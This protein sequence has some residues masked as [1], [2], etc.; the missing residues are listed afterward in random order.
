M[1]PEDVIAD[2]RRPFTGGSNT[3]ARGADRTRFA[4]FYAELDSH[5][6]VATTMDSV[7]SPSLCMATNST[8]TTRVVSHVTLRSHS[9]QS[10]S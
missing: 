4:E 9:P 7:V 1:R 2:K 3:F 10:S 8:P 5:E 6:K